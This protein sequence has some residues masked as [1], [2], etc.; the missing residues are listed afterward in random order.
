MLVKLLHFFVC[1]CLCVYNMF[2][3]LAFWKYCFRS[4]EK[5]NKNFG[6]SGDRPTTPQLTGS[7]SLSGLPA[8]DSGSFDG[9]FRKP[10]LPAPSKKKLEKSE[11]VFFFFFI[12]Q[13]ECCRSCLT[14][15]VPQTRLSRFW[16]IVASVRR[17]ETFVRDRYLRFCVLAVEG[18]SPS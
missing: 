9:P 15:F 5:A 17:W 8:K 6:D 14:Q 7:A 10:R 1:V 12:L 3:P 16:R 13:L 11:S 2:V 18:K 4:T